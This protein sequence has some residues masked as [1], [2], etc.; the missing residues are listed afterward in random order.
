MKRNCHTF[1]TELCFSVPVDEARL[2]L[3]LTREVWPISFSPS[4][5]L[6]YCTV[7]LTAQ[8]QSSMLQPEAGRK[9]HYSH[10]IQRVM[11]VGH[12][13]LPRLVHH[14][15]LKH[16]R[17]QQATVNT[18]DQQRGSLLVLKGFYHS[19][20]QV[21]NAASERLERQP[22]GWKVA[23]NNWDMHDEVCSC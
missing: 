10:D 12:V 21:S 20:V 22:F 14:H 4:S 2:T 1:I 19:H 3:F 6:H 8:P 15:T 23:G 11:K 17:C 18:L 7:S 9:L 13:E 5:Y 16:P